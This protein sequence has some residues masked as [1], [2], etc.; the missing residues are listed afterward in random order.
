MA[1]PR[2]RDYQGWSVFSAGF[3]PF[4]LAGAIQAGVAILVWLPVFYGELRL[5][6]AFAPRDW[7]VHE[8]LYGYLPAVITGFLF[9]AIP[10]WTGRLPIQGTPLVALVAVWLA[11]R[12]AV[13]FSAD[14]TWWLAMLVDAS[15]LLLVAAAA[16]REIV[17]G[18]N[19]RNLA[20]V[21]LVLVVFAGNVTF[22]LEAHFAGSA[23]Y[24]IRIGIAVVV[25]LIS[26]IG[27]RI[28][29]SFTRNWL[30]RQEPGRLPVPFGRFDKATIAGSAVAL[31]AWIFAPD[32]QVTG[33][34][35][36]LA[37]LLQ[38]ARLSRW[39]GERTFRER[40]LLVLHVGYAFVPLG[41][42][43]NAAAAFDLVPASAGIHAWMAG[44]AGVMTLAVMTRASL[45]HTGQELTASV[46]TQAIYLAI[47]VAAV[48]RICAVLHP[49]SS[50][51]LLHIA[52][53]AWMAAFFGFA[54]AYGPLLLGS[55]R[56]AAER[57]A[58]A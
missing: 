40:L 17:A 35:L 5:T 58:A 14:A 55:R 34:L 2:Y 49:A 15:F 9:T 1:V 36:G 18:K 16:A 7:H 23:D 28:I 45:G 29:P 33:G 13:T 12:I 20:V 8:M 54:L 43:L 44:A 38:L 42:L 41:L 53:F 11:G 6:S 26:L 51:I 22:H 25:L 46:G 56:R 27:G 50:E 57:K 24:A 47:I 21:A 10:N 52:G 3:R 30:V 39:A 31:L 19:W 48:A 4:F 32:Q 37:G